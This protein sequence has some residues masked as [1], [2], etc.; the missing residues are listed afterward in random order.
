[1]PRHIVPLGVALPIRRI[2][3][4]NCNMPRAIRQERYESD[5]DSEYVTTFCA[6]AARENKEKSNFKFG[7]D[8]ALR[9][10]PILQF[11]E[12]GGSPNRCSV[13]SRL[14]STLAS[15]CMLSGN[16]VGQ[17]VSRVSPRTLIDFG[18]WKLKRK[19]INTEILRSPL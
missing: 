19:Y 15:I 4:H 12:A 13:H 16:A 18:F 6:V 3:S 7:R 10:F 14:G 2:R 17:T 1:V 5:T 8:V 11:I 9:H